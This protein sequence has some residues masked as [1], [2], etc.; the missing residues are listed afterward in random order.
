MPV[1]GIDLALVDNCRSQQ[2]DAAAICCR[3][4]GSGLD[5]DITGRAGF[6]SEYGWIRIIEYAFVSGKQPTKISRIF[7]VE[8]GG[9][10]SPNIDLG[11]VGK[12]NPVLV[13]Q[14]N[15]AVC[16]QMAGNGAGI[17]APDVVEGGRSHRWLVKNNGLVCADIKIFPIENGLFA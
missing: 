12:K 14:V 13:D 5:L 17:L 3:E 1:G 4:D 8:R 6:I 11:A 7:N 16:P 9:N 10:Q 2:H 15:L